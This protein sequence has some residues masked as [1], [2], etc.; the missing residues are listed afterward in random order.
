MT[1]NPDNVSLPMSTHE[2]HPPAGDY[3]QAGQFDGHLSTSQGA[4]SRQDHT[5]TQGS[6]S[7]VSPDDG[8]AQGD[9]PSVSAER[10]LIGPTWAHAD[11]P[12]GDEC[13]GPTPGPEHECAPPPAIE[14]EQGRHWTCP[15]CGLMWMR[16]GA[17]TVDSPAALYPWKPAPATPERPA[18]PDYV[19]YASER[20]RLAMDALINTGYFTPAQVGEDVAPRIVELWAAKR[21]DL[22]KMIDEVRDLNTAKGWRDG[23]NTFGDYIAL[24]HS[25]ASEAL[26][27]YRDWKLE[28]ATGPATPIFADDEDH[29]GNVV[30]RGWSPPKPEGVGSE[31][32]DVLIRLLDMADL[33]GIDLET[34]YGRKMA[35]NWTRPYRHGGRT[36]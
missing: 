3:G 17:G 35:F 5:V 8:L 6:F 14:V 29:M 20:I 10:R 19:P 26:E 7:P 2:Q 36:L 13:Y 16:I 34:E 30:Q 27:A 21:H 31:L 1:T 18:G 12:C 11:A 9:P 28:D 33:Y 23:T 24:L 22:G 32:A 25:E 15:G 4:G